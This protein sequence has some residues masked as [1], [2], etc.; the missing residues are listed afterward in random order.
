MRFGMGKDQPGVVIFLTLGHRRRL[1]RVHRREARSEHRVRPDGDPRTSRGEAIRGG[2]AGPARPVLEGVGHRPRRAPPRD[3]PA[4]LAEPDD[5]RRRRQQERGPLHPPADQ[6]AAGWS[7]RSCAT[8]QASSGRR[9]SPS[10]SRHAGRTGG[11]PT[12]DRD[13]AGRPG[14][15]VS[16]TAPHPRAVRGPMRSIATR[17]PPPATPGWSSAASPSTPPTARPS[18]SSTRRPAVMATAPLGGRED[19]DRAVAAA[20]A[21]FEDRK[22]WATWAAGKR[23]RTLAKFAALLK[24]HSEELAQLESRNVGK[25]ISGS[26]RR[27]RSARASSSTTTPG[28]RTR[29]SARRSRSRS[30]GSTSRSASRSASSG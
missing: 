4:D 16:S 6:S 9:S 17:R 28:P 21:A 8:T 30:P 7:R 19:V 27:G 3:R 5:P 20:Q 24:D 15:R 26:A 10:S 23:G 25:P 13:A 14:G 12:T 11:H 1:G 2:V 18:R 29:S 22:G